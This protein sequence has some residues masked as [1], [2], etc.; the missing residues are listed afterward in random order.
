MIRITESELVAEL[1][2]TL[3]PEAP[4]NALTMAELCEATG[5]GRSAIKVKLRAIRAAGRLSVYRVR[6]IDDA[7]RAQIIPAYAITPA[8]PNTDQRLK[9][10]RRPSRQRS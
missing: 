6:R 9:Q 2:A 8:P 4:P 7:G 10:H 5:L 1:R 3:A